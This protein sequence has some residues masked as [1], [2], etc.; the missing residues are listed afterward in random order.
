MENGT[1]RSNGFNAA[2]C[3]TQ[4]VYNEI[5]FKKNAFRCRVLHAC[6]RPLCESLPNPRWFHCWRINRT[7]SRILRR[8]NIGSLCAVLCAWKSSIFSEEK[9]QCLSMKKK[10]HE[11]IVRFEFAGSKSA[12]SPGLYLMPSI[13]E[14][15]L[16]HKNNDGFEII[17]NPEIPAALQAEQSSCDDLN[18]G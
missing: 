4:Y 7:L 6:I 15:Y 10:M 8:S 9:S 13:C 17:A 11:S 18:S 16:R 5:S 1:W 12:L 2:R 3:T 14:R